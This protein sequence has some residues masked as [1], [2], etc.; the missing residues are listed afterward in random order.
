MPVFSEICQRYDQDN[1]ARFQHLWQLRVTDAEYESLKQEL[2]EN[3]LRPT[4]AENTY[5]RQGACLFFAEA[6]RRKG[7]R[8]TTQVY[9]ELM[10]PD[11]DDNQVNSFYNYAKE[12]AES[13]SIRPI[14]INNE[15]FFRAM[16]YEGGLPFGLFPDNDSIPNNWKSFLRSLAI[17]APNFEKLSLKTAERS[18]SL[19]GFSNQIV[20]AIDDIEK[21]PFICSPELFKRIRKG[22]IDVINTV[23]QVNPFSID[24]QLQIQP[25]QKRIIQYFVV[26]GH[27]KIP[28]RYFNDRDIND[29][30]V[31]LCLQKD[32]QLCGVFD[33]IRDNDNYIAFSNTNY[34][35]LYS[36]DA[37][38]AV[39]YND[40]STPLL[41]SFLDTDSPQLFFRVLL[42]DGEYYQRG[43]KL[44][45]SDVASVLYVPKDWCMKNGGDDVELWFENQDLYFKIYK[46]SPDI[47]NDVTLYLDGDE[48]NTKIFSIGGNQSNNEISIEGNT[49]CSLIKEPVYDVDSIRFN[50]VSVTGETIDLNRYIR[51]RRPRTNEMLKT[52]PIGQVYVQYN[53]N[54]LKFYNLGQLKVELIQIL[55]SNRTSCRMQIN[56]PH[57]VVSSPVAIKQNDGSWMIKKDR[58]IEE[59]GHSESIPFVF[60]PNGENCFTLHVKAPFQGF[61]I[62]DMNLQAVVGNQKIPFSDMTFY[63]YRMYGNDVTMKYNDG[64]EERRISFEWD[65]DK[66][67]FIRRISREVYENDKWQEKLDKKQIPFEGCLTQLFGNEKEVAVSI[68]KQMLRDGIKIYQEGD[69]NH[70]NLRPISSYP[71]SFTLYQGGN[72]CEFKIRKFP[73]RLKLQL[74]DN[75]IEMIPHCSIKLIARSIENPEQTVELI[76]DNDGFYSISEELRDMKYVILTCA[77]KGYVLPK[78]YYFD[79]RVWRHDDAEESVR[80]ALATDNQELMRSKKWF[81]IACGETDTASRYLNLRCISENPLLLLQFAYELWKDVKYNDD[82]TEYLKSNLIKFSKELN[83]QWLWLDFSF[84]DGCQEALHIPKEDHKEFMQFMKDLYVKSNNGF[85]SYQSYYIP[86]EYIR[87]LLKGDMIHINS[88]YLHH[89]TQQMVRP[90]IESLRNNQIWVNTAMR[91]ALFY[92][93][94]YQNITYIYELFRNQIY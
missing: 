90:L 60:T 35:G 5:I 34:K 22:F 40:G 80:R 7:C 20:E 78:S 25:L 46:V 55:E 94:N 10:G 26:N 9:E 87:L 69:N 39:T 89:N 30:F 56:W 50:V 84:P 65:A 76:P 54:T 44:G 37:S 59:V 18:S 11:Y 24:Y 79:D 57:G 53:G 68:H 63:R 19:L 29:D 66:K 16:L 15:H 3:E 1:N 2:R 42:E 13:L 73:F 21:M 71:F 47:E 92:Y 88:E 85:Y 28:K 14:T 86:E 33:Y 17:G 70:N 31:S 64:D 91:R 67:S 43:N 82:E 61:E 75:L 51:F 93:A 36:E 58:L 32:G 81:E 12:G 4:R 49:L 62:L 74:E 45:Y 52:S 6:F 72:R 48:N 83:F 27:N 8:D 38:V 23:R 41:T 77:Q